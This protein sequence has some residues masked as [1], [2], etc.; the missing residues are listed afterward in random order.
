MDMDSIRSLWRVG[1]V[2]L[3][4]EVD[5]RTAQREV[6]IANIEEA[7]MRGEIVE[8]REGHPYRKCTVRGWA[9]RKVADLDIGPWPLNVA[10]A[11]NDK[12]YI[13]TVYWQE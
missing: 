10:C 11:M 12:L 8:E 4:D 13:I 6:S 2:K 9:S 3:S 7:I 1:A 5:A